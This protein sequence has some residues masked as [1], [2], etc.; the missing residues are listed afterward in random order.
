MCR[1]NGDE[2]T[3]GSRGTRGHAARVGFIAAWLIAVP[4]WRAH[5]RLPV[6]T[7]DAQDSDMGFGQKCLLF[8]FSEW[9]RHSKQNMRELR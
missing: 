5:W 1:T 7:R 2:R 4:D 6:R 3:V 8:F 9:R